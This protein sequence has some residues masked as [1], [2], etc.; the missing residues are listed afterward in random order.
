MSY[1]M[2]WA[3]SANNLYDIVYSTNDLSGGV[4]SIFFLAF[5]FFATFSIFKSYPSDIAFITSSWITTI[6]SAL[7]F[8]LGFIAWYVAV[9]PLI[10]LVAGLV[11]KGFK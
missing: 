10:M 9:V 7:F 11:I 4:V 8:F 2:T 6:L 1:N 3:D 5:F